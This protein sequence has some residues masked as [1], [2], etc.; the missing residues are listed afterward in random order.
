MQRWLCSSVT[1]LLASFTTLMWVDAA[2]AQDPQIMKLASALGD[3]YR[4]TGWSEI[5]VQLRQDA[6][7]FHGSIRIERPEHAREGLGKR[8]FAAESA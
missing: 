8:H 4:G 6:V 7:P 3:A 5:V 1:A 2:H